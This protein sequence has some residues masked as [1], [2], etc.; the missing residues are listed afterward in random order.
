MLHVNHNKF[1]SL[2]EPFNQF[3]K[4]PLTRKLKFLLFLLK[5]KLKQILP[6]Y[7]DQR[8]KTCPLYA[9]HKLKAN[10]KV[11]MIRNPKVFHYSLSL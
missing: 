11:L 6:A 2:S 3:L 5:V 10:L 1:F 9:C 8:Y 4:I 7:G